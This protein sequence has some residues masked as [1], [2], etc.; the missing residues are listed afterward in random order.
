LTAPTGGVT[1]GVGV[2][3]GTTFA[4]ALVT[5]AAGVSFEGAIEGVFDLAKVSTEVWAVG[6]KI[7]W[8]NANARCSNAPTAGMR[9]IGYASAAA[10]NPTSTG[11]VRLNGQ[12][13]LIEDDSAP[14]PASY[15]TAGP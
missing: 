5:V 11:N 8:D 2:L 6:D 3:I 9:F 7:Y 10:A 14:A 4:I 1:T 13:A 12:A 15:A